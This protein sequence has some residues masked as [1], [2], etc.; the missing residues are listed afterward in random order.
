[1]GCGRHQ[2]FLAHGFHYLPVSCAAGLMERK[3]T[4]AE[5]EFEDPA[6]GNEFCRECRHFE[7]EKPNGCEIVGGKVEGGDYCIMYNPGQR[8][9][10]SILRKK[11]KV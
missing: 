2:P 11:A 5:V 8:T 7:V 10:A 4:K 6:K 9:N 3:L 1:M